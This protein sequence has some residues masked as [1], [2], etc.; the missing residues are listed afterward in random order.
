MRLLS[1][2]FPAQGTIVGSWLW[3]VYYAVKDTNQRYPFIS[4]GFDWLAFA[5]MVI[6]TVFI[7]P[8]QDP[9]KN[10]WV[11][12]FGK[13]ACCMVVPFALLAS[14]FRGLPLWWCAIDCSFGIIGFTPLSI[15][16]RQINRLEQLEKALCINRIIFPTLKNKTVYEPAH[17]NA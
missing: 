2:L 15:C 8:L 4:Y 5:H 1:S 14:T 3:K 9:V 16:L 12:Q 7:G 6:A 10:K 11:I 13:I 17:S